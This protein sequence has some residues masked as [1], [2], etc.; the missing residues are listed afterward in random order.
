MK[1]EIVKDEHCGYSISINGE[2]I[3]ECLDEQEVK[4]LTIAEL[5][6]I[7]KELECVD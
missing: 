1:F 4:G 7:A 3:L 2:T 5:M 6:N